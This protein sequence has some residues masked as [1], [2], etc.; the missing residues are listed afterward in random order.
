MNY[1]DTQIN[2]FLE[3]AVEKGITKTMRELGYPGSWSTAERWAKMRGIEVAVDPIKARARATAEFYKDEELL[4]I[5]EQGLS[6]AYDDL[7]HSRSLTADDQMKLSK[8]ISSYIKDYLTIQGRAT[9]I[10]ESRSTDGMDAGLVALLEEERRRHLEG[11][12]VAEEA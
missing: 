11:R 12:Q 8:A 2:A 7:V 5:A 6:R 1:D 4:T 9:S 10:N 3:I